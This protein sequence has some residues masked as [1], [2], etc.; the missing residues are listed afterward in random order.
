MTKHVLIVAGDPSG[1]EHGSAL[2]RALKQRV[3]SLRIIALGGFHLRQEADRFIYPLVGIGG[4]GFWEPLLKLPRLWKAW[5]EF[6]RALREERP[7][8]VVPI[9]YYGF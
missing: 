7:Q 2:A 6:K 1:D 3:P 9:D 4:F 5:W 8:A